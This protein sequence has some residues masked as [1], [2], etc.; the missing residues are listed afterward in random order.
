[1]VFLL[2]THVEEVLGRFPRKPRFFLEFPKRGVRE[3][4]PTLQYSAWQSPFRLATCDQEN[5][6]TSA[7][8][9]GGAFFQTGLPV[10]GI[11]EAH[12]MRQRVGRRSTYP[13]ILI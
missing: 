11:F 12:S 6:L 8:D 2:A 4:F 7:T 5:S 9:H 3:L 1:M 13:G 10:P